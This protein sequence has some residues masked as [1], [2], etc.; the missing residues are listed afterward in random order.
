MREEIEMK[1]TKEEEVLIG[2]LCAGAAKTQ[3][4]SCTL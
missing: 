1:L 2:D 4:N 3:R